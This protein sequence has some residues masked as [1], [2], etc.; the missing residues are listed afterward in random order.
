MPKINFT[1]LDVRSDPRQGVFVGVKQELPLIDDIVS[2]WDY[3]YTNEQGMASVD[4]VPGSNQIAIDGVLWLARL[5]DRDYTSDEAIM[6]AELRSDNFQPFSAIYT[7]P[8]YIVGRSSPQEPLDWSPAAKERV[9]HVAEDL[10]RFGEQLETLESLEQGDVS[11]LTGK[12]NENENNIVENR[13][14]IEANKEQIDDLAAPPEPSDTAPGNT[15]GSPSAGVSEKYARADHDHGIEPGQ[16]AGGV[17]QT[18]RDAAKTAQD[19]ANENRTELESEATTRRDADTALGNM[20]TALANSRPEFTTQLVVEPA[21]VAHSSDITREFSLLLGEHIDVPADTRFLA[22]FAQNRGRDTSDEVQVVPYDVRLPP[23]SVSFTIQQQDVAAVGLRSQDTGLNMALS[24]LDNSRQVIGDKA[25]TV[26]FAIGIGGAFGSEG[27]LR[28][29]GDTYQR[30]TF[31]SETSLNAQLAV[32]RANDD[33]AI[34]VP[35][36]NFTGG[37]REYEVGQSYYLAPHHSAELLMVLIAEGGPGEKASPAFLLHSFEAGNVAL[38]QNTWTAVATLTVPRAQIAGPLLI[39][40]DA[41]ADRTRGAGTVSLRLRRGSAVI[42]DESNEVEVS[43]QAEHEQM[44]LITTDTPPATEDAVYTVEVNHASSSLQGTVHARELVAM[45]PGSAPDVSIDGDAR[46]A[47]IDNKARLDALPPYSTIVPEP[48]GISDATFPE[49]LDFVFTERIGARTITA[50][51][52]S[53]SGQT[54]GIALDASTPVARV[55]DRGRLRFTLTQALRDTLGNNAAPPTQDVQFALTLSLSDGAKHIHNGTFLVN[56]SSLAGGSTGSGG[57]KTRGDLWATLAFTSADQGR[58]FL[59]RPTISTEGTDAGVTLEQSPFGQTTRLGIQM[60]SVPPS[61]DIIGVWVV[62]EI[63][64]KDT[65]ALF[66]PYGSVYSTTFFVWQSPNAAS[67][68]QPISITMAAEIRTKPTPSTD[69]VWEIDPG[70]VTLENRIGNPRRPDFNV[71][72]Y[73]AT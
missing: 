70:N 6:G 28:A 32:H 31:S 44:V 64:G 10:A 67:A 37:V 52:L 19:T 9:T 2:K 1:V 7:N 27:E 73:A 24:F 14:N 39:A 62:G 15:P 18:A 17:D 16:Q 33:A 12:V 29:A 61:D 3:R 43:G 41:T 8:D 63:A 55:T 25:F 26:P 71:K 50:A 30:L 5:E 42:R 13:R 72:I 38:V 45:S 22:V 49:H 58:S 40:F 65:N 4:F 34:F 56:D 51:E 60:P 68:Y 53:I 69:I 36:A 59:D 47:A 57:G 66:I 48:A 46:K 20:I 21:G 54:A 23:Q 11:R 35:T